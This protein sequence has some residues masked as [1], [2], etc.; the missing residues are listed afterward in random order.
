MTSLLNVAP[1]VFAV[2]VSLS[3]L[4][5]AQSSA[6]HVRHEDTIKSYYDQ[7][8]ELGRLRMEYWDASHLLEM[9]DN[10]ALAKHDI[11]LALTPLTEPARHELLLRERAIATRIFTVFEETYYDRERAKKHGDDD[12]VEF[13]NEVLGYFTGRLLAN[14]RLRWLW[15]HH[16]GNL[17]A[18]FEPETLRLYDE[19]LSDASCLPVGDSADEVDAVGPYPAGPH[20]ILSSEDDPS[21]VSP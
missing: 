12:R 3:A 20:R 17:C 11:S 21:M 1:G 13:L 7:F 18:Y 14:P 19:A 6:R 15:S 9:P 10:Y 8:D 4:Y 16:G 2:A 5:F